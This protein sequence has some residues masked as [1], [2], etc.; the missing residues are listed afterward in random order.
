MSDDQIIQDAADVMNRIREL[1]EA[2]RPFVEAF[3]MHE[4]S[5][6]P[7]SRLKARIMM[8]LSLGDFKRLRDVLTG[9][10]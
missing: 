2:A 5:G 9:E 10:V 6:E 1:E 4:H 8:D 7:I 3:E